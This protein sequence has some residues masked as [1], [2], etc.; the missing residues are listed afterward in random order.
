MPIREIGIWLTLL[1]IIVAA[2]SFSCG[3]DSQDS[4]VDGTPVSPESSKLLDSDLQLTCLRIRN[5]ST[6][7]IDSLT[8]I[9]PRE[10]VNY[11]NLG[12]GETSECTQFENGVYRYAAYRITFNGISYNQSVTDWMGEKPL[13]GEAVTYAIEVDPAHHFGPVLSLQVIVDEEVK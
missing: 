12:A 10:K 11:K 6:Y 9:F 2:L 1:V 7:D 5:N 3:N 8:V 13:Q 4:P